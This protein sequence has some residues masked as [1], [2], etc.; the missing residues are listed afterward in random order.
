MSEVL[1]D[2]QFFDDLNKKLA[3]VRDFFKKNIILFFI[4]GIVIFLLIL[5][6]QVI[7]GLLFNP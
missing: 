4:F 6:Q 7:L 2:Q 3:A 1:F 5:F